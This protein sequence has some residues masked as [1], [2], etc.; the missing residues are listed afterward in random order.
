MTPLQSPSAPPFEPA[1]SLQEDPKTGESEEEWDGVD[2]SEDSDN[3]GDGDKFTVECTQEEVKK[4]TE[5][6]LSLDVSEGGNN[7]ATLFTYNLQGRRRGCEDMSDEPLFP[8]VHKELY[9]VPTISALQKLHDN[10]NPYT[11]KKENVTQEKIQ[12][13][14]NFIEAC[15]NTKVMKRVHE[16][17][18]SKGLAVKD[19]VIFKTFLHELWF[20]PYSRS[21]GVEGS[22]AFEH[23]FLGEVKG[24]RE[25]TGFHSWFFFLEQERER[26]VDYY[27][28]DAGKPLFLRKDNN[29][30]KR[31]VGCVIKAAFE[32][33][34]IKKGKKG[35]KNEK[36]LVK[37]VSSFFLGFS[38]ELELAI[39]T[40]C[41][42]V[43]PGKAVPISLAGEP[44]NVRTH[45]L[46]RGGKEYLGAA[47]PEL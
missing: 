41:F 8:E 34:G 44:I 37:L 45:V 25:V 28:F 19:K 12:E 21:H 46:K 29:C 31:N 47:Y 43:G 23:V 9:D 2:V 32:W 30:V 33:N 39:Y 26:K 20:A 15:I 40:I 10:Y 6:L 35:K 13:Q 14:L 22:S 7:C 27:G 17:L 3:G 38:P 24:D 4:L 18:V 42:L 36:D 16:W 1:L 11:N 5:D